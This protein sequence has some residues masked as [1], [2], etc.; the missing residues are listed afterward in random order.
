[1]G[2]LNPSVT[3]AELMER[4]SSFGTVS[5]VDF[6]RKEEN[7][8]AYLSI[9]LDDAQWKKMQNSYHNSYWKS[10]KLRIA[11]AKKSYMERLAEKPTEKKE[12][13]TA[14]GL[15]LH[16]KNMEL[17][18]DAEKCRRGWKKGRNGRAIALVRLRKERNHF[19]VVD[20]DHYR[21][22]IQRLFGTKP[23]LP[24]TRLHFRYED[25]DGNSIASY[26]TESEISADEEIEEER[27]GNKVENITENKVEQ[28]TNSSTN[29]N[30]VLSS[31][32]KKEPVF[33]SLISNVEITND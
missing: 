21:E 16:A 18:S 12:K 1:M 26:D 7:V 8:F 17:V 2:G 27:T 33:F 3:E 4:F 23:P 14:G 32:K 25:F 9:E 13:K 15:Y 30:L 5:S 28:R 6:I 11:E 24:V 29:D 31:K 22:N 20:P 19:I 10:M